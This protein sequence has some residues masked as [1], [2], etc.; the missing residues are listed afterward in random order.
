MRILYTTDLH[1]RIEYYKRIME[2]A[3]Y[4][5]FHMVINGGDLYPKEGDLYRQKSFLTSF[6]KRHLEEYERE[7][8]YYLT[9]PG[10]DDLMVFDP[11]FERILSPYEF[12]KDIAGKRVTIDGYEFIGMNWVTDYPFRLKDRCRRDG[13]GYVVGEQLGSGL[14]S[15]ENG[16][17]EIE[18]WPT[19]LSQ[20]CTIEEELERLPIPENRRK[21]IYIIHMPPAS[22]GLDVCFDGRKVGSQAIYSFIQHREPLLTLHGHIHESPLKSYRWK[23]SL[24]ETLCIQPGQIDGFTYVTIDLERIEFKRIVEKL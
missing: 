10:N 23:N 15:R 4:G 5:H 7:E 12:C 8:I 18:D 6:F 24:G 13:E 11:L 19:Y 3:I 2:I 1:G 9:M 20:R 16:F 14:L 21:A 17:H 22:L